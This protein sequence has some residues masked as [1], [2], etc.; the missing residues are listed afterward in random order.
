MESQHQSQPALFSSTRRFGR[1]EP[2]RRFDDLSSGHSSASVGTRSVGKMTVDCR[3]LFK[4][5]RWGVLGDNRFPAGIIYLD[6]N[7]GPPQGCKVKSATVTVTLDDADRCLHPYR[8]RSDR[9][10]HTSN[11]PVQMTDWY[12][13]KQLIGEEK[14]TEFKRTMRMAPEL[15]VMGGGASGV[16]VDSEKTFK[17]S[18]RWTFNGQL[19]P[20]KNTWTY[21]TLKW[22]LKD[23]DF[24]IQ[25]SRSS[26][27]HTAFA[28]E[29]AGQPFLMKVEIEG[30]L[31]KWKH[32]VKSKLRFGSSKNQD[33]G[34]TTTLID[35]KSPELF[36]SRLDE[37]ARSLPRAMEMENYEAIPVEIPDTLPA[38]FQPT[39]PDTESSDSIDTE[40]QQS[41]ITQQET[42]NNTVNLP[43]LGAARVPQCLCNQQNPAPHGLAEPTLENIKQ[44]AHALA[45]LSER[46]RISVPC[47]KSFPSSSNTDVAEEEEQEQSSNN[48]V[49]GKTELVSVNPEVDEEAMLRIL[50]VPALLAVL[51]MLATL[52]NMLGASKGK[53]KR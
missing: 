16:G 37:L 47:L 8:T 11:C 7:F 15:H 40:T 31:E 3:F 12:G 35:F 53:P 20:G 27:V 14:S 25:A 22:D 29:H 48:Q 36:Q 50:R 39:S 6:L 46:Q 30:K 38:S 1:Y 2:F 13:P 17:Y 45:H 23:N 24:E 32:R 9:A 5:S 51:Q 34:Q 41:H 52:M 33:E 10:Y 4:K 26:R 28:F 44:V 19:L 43:S 21:K 42:L 49:K 18:S